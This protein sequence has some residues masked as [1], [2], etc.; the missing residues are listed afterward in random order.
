MVSRGEVH[1]PVHAAAHADHS[2]GTQMVRDQLRR[3]ACRGRL[4]RREEPVLG[5]RDLEEVVPVGRA[6][7]RPVHARTLSQALVLCKVAATPGARNFERIG[8][9]AFGF[10]AARAGEVT[11]MD[12]GRH[13]RWMHDCF[14]YASGE[15]SW[16]RHVTPLNPRSPLLRSRSQAPANYSSESPKDSQPRASQPRA[17]TKGSVQSTGLAGSGGV[18]EALKTVLEARNVQSVRRIG[19][20]P[21]RVG[22][23]PEP[24]HQTRR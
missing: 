24:R 5:R 6:A 9:A 12:G 8:P 13:Q 23:P 10:W 11:G 16:E 14:P 15:A 2:P 7:G 20:Q 3:V 18:S 1:D 22:D 4:P 19:L 17:L 21:R